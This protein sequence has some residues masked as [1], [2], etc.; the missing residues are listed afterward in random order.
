MNFMPA[1]RDCCEALSG[2]RIWVFFAR[3][4]L[5]LQFKSYKV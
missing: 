3:L 1:C 5:G 4:H 2:I